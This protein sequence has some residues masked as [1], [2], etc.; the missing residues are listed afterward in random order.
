MTIAIKVG[1]TNVYADLGYSDAAEMQ[2]KS[3]LA[4]EIARAIK[5]RHLTQEAAAD[6]LGV[7][8]AKISKITRGQF[9]RVSEG[10]MLE[11]V[12]KLRHDVP[13]IAGKA[14]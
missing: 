12:S 8:Q 4:A 2:R 5:A 10:K 14:K 3:S 9:R 6:L 11:L 7:D 1:S 13:I